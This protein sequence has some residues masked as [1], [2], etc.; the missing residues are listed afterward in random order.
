MRPS[1][2][3]AFL[4]PTV[5]ILLLVTAVHAD[6]TETNK[7]GTPGGGLDY[8][9]HWVAA[10]NGANPAPATT[11]DTAA[12]LA[13]WYG[14]DPGWIGNVV[15]ITDADAT[16]YAAANK[17]E[18]FTDVQAT[19]SVSTTDLDEEF[20]VMVRA[21][22]FDHADPVT[23]VTA[24]AATFSANN[25]MNPGDPME[26]NLYKIINGAIDNSQTLNPR[27]P[28]GFDDLIVTIE[29]SAVGSSIT[30]KLFE[31]ADSTNALAII[32]FDEP[33]NELPDGYTGVINLD[34]ESADGISAYYDTLSSVTIPEPATLTLLTAALLILPKRKR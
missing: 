7:D 5:G 23:N 25:A 6:W 34:Y 1:R 18:S 30:A 14:T 13:T 31:D 12:N 15:N 21:S 11:W 10:W 33:G 9:E 32:T 26:F 4:L 19:V 22:A 17:V 2:K 20:G 8:L 27:V 28:A 29:L 3:P 24:Y 16:A